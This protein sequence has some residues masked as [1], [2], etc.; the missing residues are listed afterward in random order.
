MN[1]HIKIDF[2][3]GQIVYFKNDPEQKPYIVTGGRFSPL[4]VSYY[5]CHI[6]DQ[7]EA[8]KIE[9]SR[10]KNER[11]PASYV[12]GSVKEPE[13]ETFLSDLCIEDVHLSVRAYNMLKKHKIDT[14]AQMRKVSK[15]DFTAMHGIGQSILK[16][17][18]QVLETYD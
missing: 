17:I 15:E 6:G 12:F 14:V 8:F 16:E 18:S 4:G 2:E 10:D 13:K 7:K 1:I 11:R 9:L 3:I 5:V